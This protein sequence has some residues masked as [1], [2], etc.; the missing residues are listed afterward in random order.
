[1]DRVR[2]YVPPD[3]HKFFWDEA[4]LAMFVMIE[5]FDKRRDGET[6]RLCRPSSN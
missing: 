2:A 5:A 4:Y 3:D 6:I 1:M